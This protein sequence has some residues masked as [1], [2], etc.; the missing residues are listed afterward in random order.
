MPYVPNVPPSMPA[1]G[2]VFEDV[3]GAVAVL[4]ATPF[5][6]TPVDDLVHAIRATSARPSVDDE[7]ALS[8][9]GESLVR[10]ALDHVADCVAFKS[11]VAE[12][13]HFYSVVYPTTQ[14]G[15][16]RSWCASDKLGVPYCRRFSGSPPHRHLLGT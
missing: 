16:L 12:V 2:P 8:Q 3:D 15:I 1:P 14:T 13:K 11:C 4:A 7:A 5:V 9:T 10:E 6:P